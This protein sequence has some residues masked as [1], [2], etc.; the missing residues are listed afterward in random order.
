MFLRPS[1]ERPDPALEFIR[2][3]DPAAFLAAAAPLL[4]RNRAANSGFVSWVKAFARNPPATGEVVLLATVHANKDPVAIALRRGGGPLILGDSAA[5][6]AATIADALVAEMPDLQGIVGGLAACEAFARTWRKATGRA[7]TLRFHLRDYALTA[8]P[9]P[10][11][12]PGAARPAT[13]DDAAWL[14]DWLVAFVTEA[15]VADDPQRA[16]SSVPKRIADGRLWIW[17][18]AGAKSMLGAF[19][20]DDTAARIAP[21]YT[22][23]AYRGRGYASALAA[24][25]SR[26]LLARGKRVVYLTT[27]LS[28]ATSNGIYQRIGY[29]PVGDQYQFDFVVPMGS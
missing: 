1:S 24:S 2:H 14:G 20:V 7:H 9:P 3:D 25:V 23:L 12:T 10:A 28:N 6:G 21:V 19:E 22:P 29:R 27:D 16:R 17:E 26:T 15:R 11:L 5:A 8:T 18:D 13:E 4:E